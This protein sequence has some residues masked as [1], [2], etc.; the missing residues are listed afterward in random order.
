MQHARMCLER[1]RQVREAARDKE[2]AYLFRTRLHRLLLSV[3]RL[4]ASEYGHEVAVPRTLD[5]ALN[6]DQRNRELAAISSSM[7]LSSKYM[8]QRSVALDM[9]WEAEWGSICEKIDRIELLLLQIL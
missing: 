4:V 9:R 3:Q 8:S 6:F 1:V 5:A 2:S 7:V